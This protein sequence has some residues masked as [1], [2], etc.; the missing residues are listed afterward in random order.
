MKNWWK[1]FF[2]P[3]TAEVMFKPRQGKIAQLEVDQVL[4]QLGNPK[5]RKIL[6]LCCGEG[7]HSVLF[8]HKGHEV[9]GLDYS[10]NFLQ[11][12]RVQ[13]AKKKA[14]V[15]FVKGDMKKTSQ[16]FAKDNFDVVTSLYNSFGYFDKRSDDIKTIK[17]VNK[18]LKPGGYFIINTLN[19]DGVKVRLAKPLQSGYELSKN[20]FMLDHAH[21]D[22]KKMK[23]H[24][25]WTIIDAR[26]KKTAIFRREF[27][28]N[29]YT[30]KELK[31]ILK[32]NGFRIV[33]TW[34]LLMGEVFNE[35]KSWHQTILAQKIK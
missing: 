18:V 31:D 9:V 23:T 13:A 15:R 21:L 34:G 29:V 30:H 35:K 6:D 32:K 19:G 3:V 16:Y 26:K 28:Q 1:N 5:H 2:K 22:F 4:K 11:V 20:F 12:A 10:S 7:R 25:K 33:K 17:E 24:A 8:S 14:D 27:G